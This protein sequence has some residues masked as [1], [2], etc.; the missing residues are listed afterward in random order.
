MKNLLSILLMTLAGV[1]AQAQNKPLACQ[2][3][4]ASGLNWDKGRWA[5]SV[6]KTSKFILV[7]E[8]NTLTRESVARA[9]DASPIQITCSNDDYRI[10][11]NAI[12]NFL[13]FDPRTLKG[14]ISGLMGSTMPDGNYKDSIYVR[15]FTCQPY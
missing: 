2:D 11:C 8:G 1:S 3:D 6:F 9:M 12:Y 10:S 5:T 7:Q 15:A 4:A 14:G 13:Y